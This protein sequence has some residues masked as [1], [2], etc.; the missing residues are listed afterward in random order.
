M[1]R[2]GS[3]G[4]TAAVH[5]ANPALDLDAHTL[6]G[7]AVLGV[8]GTLET[9]RHLCEVGEDGVFDGCD[10]ALSIGAYVR[11]F[12]RKS[13]KKSEKSLDSASDLTDT[14]YMEDPTHHHRPTRIGGV[15]VDEDGEPVEEPDDDYF[16]GPDD[17]DREPPAHWEP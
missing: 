8:A 3:A 9:V 12:S 15:L 14:I 1:S 16:E 17:D 13:R 10:H 4:P 2:S 5:L 6:A 7:A 11:T